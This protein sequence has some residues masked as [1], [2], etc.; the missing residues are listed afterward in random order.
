MGRRIFAIHTL[1]QNKKPEHD[2]SF[3]FFILY[4]SAF[5]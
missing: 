1:E 2:V 4:L 3:V 5:N